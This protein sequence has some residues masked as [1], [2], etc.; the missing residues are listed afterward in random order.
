MADPLVEAIIP[1]NYR[2]RKALD[3]MFEKIEIEEISQ[4]EAMSTRFSVI[5]LEPWEE[6]GWI[7]NSSFGL[8]KSAL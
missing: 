5:P 2:D 4:I 3:Q 7:V 6:K 8:R 1:L